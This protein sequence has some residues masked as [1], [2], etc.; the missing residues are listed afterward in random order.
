MQR[1]GSPDAVHNSLFYTYHH[2]AQHYALPLCQ[3][4]K[5]HKL[6]AVQG[7]VR[8][9]LA[10]LATTNYKQ[11]YKASISPVLKEG[12][13]EKELQLLGQLDYGNPFFDDQV[14]NL[15]L[16]KSLAFDL[17]QTISLIR[18]KEFYTKA[19]VIA[20]HPEFKEIISR[21]PADVSHAFQLKITQLKEEI[22]TMKIEQISPYIITCGEEAVNTRF[23]IVLS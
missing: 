4:V 17:G 22:A 3:P 14:R 7:C 20:E 18:G 10:V 12:N 13:W 16:C 2:H 21:Q 23:G 6:L 15:G 9:L 1:R 11:F 8:N 19:E 5:R